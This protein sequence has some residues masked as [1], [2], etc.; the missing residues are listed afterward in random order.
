MRIVHVFEEEDRTIWKHHMRAFFGHTPNND[1]EYNPENQSYIACYCGGR[2]Y[3]IGD[4][5]SKEAVCAIWH[6]KVTPKGV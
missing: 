3:P 2:L 6:N 4:D 5:N 1:E